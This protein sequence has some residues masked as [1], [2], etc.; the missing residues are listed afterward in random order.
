[1]K[2][3]RLVVLILLG[4]A[5]RAVAQDL[6]YTQFYHNPMHYS[7]A[8]AGAFQGDLRAMAIYRGQ[9]TSVPVSYQTFALGVDRKLLEFGSNAVGT[10]LLVQHD[11]AGD[12]G[13]SWTQIG[14]AGSVAHQIDEW[15]TL[16]AGFGLGIVQ[17]RFYISG[18][19]FKNQW[20]GEVFD[21][22]LPARESFNRTTGLKPTFSAGLNWRLKAPG[23]RTRVVAGVGVFHLNRPG[24]HFDENSAARLPLRL[25]GNANSYLQVN[26][27]LDLVVF[28]GAQQMQSAREILVGGGARIWLNPEETALQF[29]LA[30]RLGDAITPA[31]Q[32]EFG[33]WTLG[34]SYDWNISPFE[35]ATTGRG[36]FEMAVVYR[37][38]PAPPVKA[39]KSCPV[40]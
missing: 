31:L 12:A 16:S 3:I 14:L 6:H 13:L 38:V 23:T 26:Q 1:M 24:I 22:G 18:L 17:R 40:F 10:G 37:S 28:A 19:K 27:F 36:G 9:W 11:K 29:T 39:F 20:T 30:T 7:P 2:H 5:V 25:A 4:L 34:L 33:D 15:N 8:Q 35:S 21:P 32:Y